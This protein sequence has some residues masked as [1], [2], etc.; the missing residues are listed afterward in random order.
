MAKKLW[1]KN[2]RRIPC[3]GVMPSE[4]PPGGYLGMDSLWSTSLELSVAERE[5][6][7]KYAYYFARYVDP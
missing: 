7:A 3:G 5:K 1:V 6:Y 4:L 2:G